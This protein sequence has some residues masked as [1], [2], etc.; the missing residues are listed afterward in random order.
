LENKTVQIDAL[1]SGSL[2]LNSQFYPSLGRA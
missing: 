2:F 1:R